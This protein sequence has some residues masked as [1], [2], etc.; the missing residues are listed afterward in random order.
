[1]TRG[2]AIPLVPPVPT[3]RF[4][5]TPPGR[6][7]LIC[8]CHLRWNFVYQRPQHLLTRFARDRR[9]FFIEEPVFDS[10]VPR[11]E[12]ARDGSGVYVVVPH[13]PGGAS[14]AATAARMRELVDGLLVRHRL[15]RY[16]LWYYTPMALAFSDH[17]T[18]LAT[19]YDCMDELSA[20]AHAPAG[21]RAAERELMRR[22]DVMLTGG[23]TLFESKR[24]LHRNVHA[25]PSSVDV[26]HFARARR[27]TSDPDDQARVGSPRL[28]FFGVLDE[29]LDVPLLAACAARRPDWHFVLVGPIVKIDP[30]MLPQAPN[31]HYL[32]PKA[33]AQL[34]EYIA[35]WDVALLPFARNDATRFISPT[36]TPEYLAAGRPV[37]STSIR[38]VVHP[39]GDLGLARIADTPDLFVAAIEAALQENAGERLAAAD[40]FLARM[41]WD[42]TWSF[43]ESLLR[44][45]VAGRQTTSAVQSTAILGRD[46]EPCSITSS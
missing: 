13:L 7:D 5:K 33:Y 14:A 39:Y 32:G 37:V 34:P 21:L 35:G 4:A 11:L 31:I 41:S 1:M 2:V 20:F 16:V 3:P 40:A 29:R 44:Q 22:S 19:L 9:V 30:A 10:D 42:A 38:D 27:V 17:L 6:E 46:Q 28:G 15:E 26:A 18:P 45:A 36:K 12:I 24:Q 25:V 43:V 23:H 8:F